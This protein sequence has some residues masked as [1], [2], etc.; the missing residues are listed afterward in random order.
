M[1]E[2]TYLDSF[3]FNGSQYPLNTIVKVKNNIYL[4]EHNIGKMSNH[5]MVQVVQSFIDWKGIHRWTYAIWLKSG[6]I[7]E[8]TTSESPDTMIESI[9]GFP[10]SEQDNRQQYYYDWEVPDVITGWIIFIIVMV[11]GVFLRDRW[12]LWI[13]GSIYFYLWRKF[14]LR[15]TTKYAY[16]FDIEKK[17][18]SWNERQT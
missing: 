11:V 17:V 18:R 8:Y 2:R 13:I 7:V 4:V 14:K 9:V 12:T 16:G 15:K 10:Y 3:V 5:P 1:I 6:S